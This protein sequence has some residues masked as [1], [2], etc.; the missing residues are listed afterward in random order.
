MRARRLVSLCVI[1]FVFT[2]AWSAEPTVVGKWRGS[3]PS[4]VGPL[5]IT[6]VF[7]KDHS[8]KASGAKTIRGRRA[9][10]SFTGTWSITKSGRDRIFDMTMTTMTMNG[11]KQ[12]V[13]PD[14]SVPCKITFAKDTFT[15]WEPSGPVKFKRVKK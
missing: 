11:V 12:T 2:A 3:L 7:K 10:Y 15:V 14:T 13:P 6:I 8:F 5:P 1:A 9:T 4:P